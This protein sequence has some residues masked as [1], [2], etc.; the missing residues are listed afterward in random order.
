MFAADAEA[1]DPPDTMG[2]RL[3]EARGKMK[4]PMMVQLLKENKK[5]PVESCAE[6]TTERLKQWEYGNNPISHEWILSR[7][8]ASFSASL[9]ITISCKALSKFAL[10]KRKFNAS[11]NDN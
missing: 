1:R 4:R 7:L 11:G 2:A 9:N 5:A 10:T 6:M 3:R 8:N